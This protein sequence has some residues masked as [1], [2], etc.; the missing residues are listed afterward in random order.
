MAVFPDG[1]PQTGDG[2]SH[3]RGRKFSKRELASVWIQE[4]GPPEDAGIAAEIAYS[5]SRG[6]EGAVSPTGCR[7]A[8][9]NCPPSPDDLH[10]RQNARH[11]IAKWAGGSG[12]GHWTK[13]N[14]RAAQL[15]AAHQ[16]NP[17]RFARNIP[18]DAA[19]FN[20]LDPFGGVP[21]PPFPNPF[22]SG[23]GD[24]SPFPDLPNPLAGVEAVA[25][26]LTA[27]VNTLRDAFDWLTSAETWFGLGK[28]LF[29][30][31]LAAMGLRGALKAAGV[32]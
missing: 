11:A 22:D 23:P 9:Q 10:I 32:R 3:W 27:M 8:W 7:G 16:A 2:R 14:S 31:I 20:P 19:R 4:G 18:A 29:G 25:K 13:F 6:Y 1:I 21:L 15:V 12:A 5:E 30:A 26:A 28:I 24:E 17:K